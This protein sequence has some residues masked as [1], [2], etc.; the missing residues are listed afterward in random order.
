[1][2]I[3]PQH[4]SLCIKE[5]DS[6]S[7]QIEM[8]LLDTINDDNN[9]T[10][11]EWLY[12]SRGDFF[13]ELYDYVNAIEDYTKALDIEPDSYVALVQRGIAY[14][15]SAK[16]VAA[17]LDFD[18]AIQIDPNRVDA[19]FNKAVNLGFQGSPADAITEYNILI[20]LIDSP[21]VLACR[22]CCW[23]E[24]GMEEKAMTDY[25]SAIRLQ[26]DF[27]AALFNRAL[28][29]HNRKSY[30]DALSDLNQAIRIQAHH[31]DWYIER[32]QIH[33]HLSNFLSALDD[34]SLA[35]HLDRANAD[36]FIKRGEL[37]QRLHYIELAIKD[38]EAAL[39][40]SPDRID[41]YEKISRLNN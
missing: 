36:L 26:P 6:L 11:L 39:Q 41:I 5:I 20:L 17:N 15:Y 4:I 32:A 12:I 2:S 10:D 40:I 16:H 38:Y 22:A 14:S 13:S 31:T 19:H 35:I 9:N 23:Q 34:L 27:A 7:F 3:D 37:W 28:I 25:N 33:Y 30:Q 24:L 8:L 1:M 21:L 18:R 29:H